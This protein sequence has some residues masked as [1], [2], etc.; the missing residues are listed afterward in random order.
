[1]RTAPATP[2]LLVRALLVGSTSLAMAM[3]A[4]AV[5]GGGVPRSALAAG[6]LVASV[7]P[8]AVGAARG[9]LTLPRLV[10][11]LGLL[12]VLLHAELSVLVG[13]GAHTASSVGG[14]TG[15]AAHGV[16][17]AA[18]AGRLSADAAAAASAAPV[19]DSGGLLMVAAHVV[20]VALVAGVLA[21]GDRAARWV[22]AWM[23]AVALLVR[24]ASL[25]VPSRPACAVVA[26]ALVVSRVLGRLLGH[27][28]RFRGPPVPD[29]R[30]AATLAPGAA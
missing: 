22:V 12:Q 23:S 29:R 5:A 18:L 17:P 7:L 8:A 2:V 26:D 27:G 24:R 6:V 19:H 28:L 25:P 21:S 20:A 14:L 13:H 4:H 16:D 15:H 3:A 30:A 9:A 11:V 1:M 10:P